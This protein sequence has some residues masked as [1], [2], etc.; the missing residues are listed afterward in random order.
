MKKFFTLIAVALC[1]MTAQAQASLEFCYE[2][3]TIIPNGSV[4]TVNTPDP[5]RLLDDEIFFESGVY[6]KNT[7]GSTVNS[8][9]V[10]NLTEIAEDSELSVC[11]G[12]NCNMYRTLGEH[13]IANVDLAAG[14][15]SSMQC[16]WSPAYDWDEDEYVYGSC[17]GTYTLK[18]GSTACSTIT[19]KFDYQDPAGISNVASASNVVATYDLQG[20]QASASKGISIVRMSDGTVRKVLNK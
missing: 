13:S 1:A 14:S 2:D 19:V 20:R 8:T 9:L 6:I 5:E 4:V 16:H 10:F 18:A 11:L 12:T 17:I 7:T 15:I 3:G